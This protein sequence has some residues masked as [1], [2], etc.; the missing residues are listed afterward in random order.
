MTGLRPWLIILAGLVTMGVSPPQGDRDPA[1]YSVRVPIVLTG[2]APVQRF[3]VPEAALIASQS[4]DMSDVRV[5][6]ANGRQ[7]RCWK[8]RAF[9]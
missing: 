8:V 3:T 5:F 9:R 2:Q 4:D 1:S 7:A 6:D